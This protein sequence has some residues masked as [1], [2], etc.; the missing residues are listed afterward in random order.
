LVAAEFARE[1]GQTLI[2]FSSGERRN[3]YAGANRVNPSGGQNLNDESSTW[4]RRLDA[5]YDAR[6][7]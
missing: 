5:I 2:G 1:S 6:R 3:I 7:A 4:R